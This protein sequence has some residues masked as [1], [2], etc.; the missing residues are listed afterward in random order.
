MA[1][2]SSSASTSE[3]PRFYYYS[4]SLLSSS[5]SSVGITPGD[6]AIVLLSAALVCLM[7]P[8]LAFFY[9]GL[10]RRKNVLNIMLQNFISMGLVTTIWYL[11]GFSLAFGEDQ[12]GVIGSLEYFGLRKVGMKPS[13]VYAPTIP[14]L[15]FFVF[16]EMFAIITPALI[17][18]AIAERVNFSAWTIFLALWSLLVYIPVCHWVWGHG[19][20]LYDLGVKDFA[21]G[22]VVHCTAGMSAVAGVLVIGRRR[23]VDESGPHNVA[24]VAL[25]TGLLW[26]GWFGFN[27]GSARAANADAAMAYVTTDVSG[28]AAMM[29]WVVLDLIKNKKPSMVGMLTGGVAGLATVTPCAGYIRPWAAFLIGLFASTMSYGAV[30]IKKRVGWD[31][32][33]DVWACHGVAG[34][35]GAILL[36]VFAQ[37]SVAGVSGLIEGNFRQFGIQV[38]AAAIVGTWSILV[39]VVLL[40]AINL[41]IRIRVPEDVELVGLDMITTA[42]HG[43]YDYDREA[44]SL[45]EMGSGEDIIK[46]P[47]GEEFDNTHTP[48][49][50]GDVQLEDIVVEPPQPSHIEEAATPH[51]ENLYT[52]PTATTTTTTTTTDTSMSGST[53]TTCTCTS[54]STKRKIRSRKPKQHQHNPHNDEKPPEEGH[55]P[56]RPKKKRRKPSSGHEL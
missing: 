5:S 10:V 38:A 12:G 48:L 27:G 4:S 55:Q 45:A 36:G 39:T 15:A 3:S 44:G 53:G 40:L 25:G 20:F 26:F 6:T 34:T 17:T 54:T 31:D 19:G 49:G 33:L 47:S 21:G 35:L 24:Y 51:D 50:T 32:A 56:H 41:G 7:T 52:T 13:P 46:D 30:L 16:Q 23:L 42:D 29:V 22:L 1:S 9:G 43:A 14:F 28:S 37:E 8:G 2:S 18:G 11:G